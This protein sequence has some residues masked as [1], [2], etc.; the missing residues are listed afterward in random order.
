VIG[1]APVLAIQLVMGAAADLSQ[2]GSGTVAVQSALI[3]TPLRHVTGTAL[4]VAGGIALLVVLR[5]ILLKRRKAAAG[6]T[7]D[8]GYAY[9]SPR[10]QYTSA[11]FAEPLIRVFRQVIQPRQR[12]LPPTGY[13]PGY[14]A[15]SSDTPD[16]FGERTYRPAWHM[17]LSLDTRL[18]WL[19]QGRL[20]LYL[21]Y[22]VVTLAVLLVW[23]FGFAG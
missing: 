15:F 16:M 2:S 13:F 23:L 8:C 5:N 11:S 22:I 7:W 14:A 4:A 19:Q 12:L 20:H 3:E 17:I 1:L 6:P 9:P 10:M 21:L 18:R